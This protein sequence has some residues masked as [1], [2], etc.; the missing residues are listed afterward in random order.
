MTTRPIPRHHSDSKELSERKSFLR[1]LKYAFPP[2]V[3]ILF[4]N[5]T[6]INQNVPVQVILAFC[7]LCVPW[8]GYLNWQQNRSHRIPIFAIVTAIYILYFA[9]PLFWGSRTIPVYY[10]VELTASED[11]ITA[12][13]ML[14]LVGLLAIW[15]GL[16]IPLQSLK[17]RIIVNPNVP[18]KNGVISWNYVRLVLIVGIAIST[19]EAA[20]YWFG[21]AGRQIMLGLLNTF[22]LVAALLLF[23]RILEGEADKIDT[24]LVFAFLLS[25]GVLNLALGWVGPLVS[26]GIGFG[27]LYVAKKRSFPWLLLLAAIFYVL[28][29]QSSKSGFRTAFWNADEISSPLSRVGFWI[30]NSVQMWTEVSADSTGQLFNENLVGAADRLSLLTQTAYVLEQTPALVPFQNG[31]LYVNILTAPIPRFLW[32]DKPSTSDPNRFYQ[33]A[34]R[35]TPPD[36]LNTVSISIGYLVEG[37]INFGWAGVAGVGFLIGLLLRVL[38]S[39]FLNSESHVFRFISGVM[40]LL[41]IINV[42]AQLGL[43]LPSLLVQSWLLVMFFLPLKLFTQVHE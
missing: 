23:N 29:F 15:A 5:V 4:L 16:R 20:P 42:E 11:Q 34:Y 12:S 2:F 7:M 3:A 26:L 9:L 43:L 38:Q 37:Y 14:V 41:T 24:V 25:K 1:P 28:F 30:E 8:F 18:D 39:H 21:E 32:L 17:T 19:N 10:A 27:L 40:L 22:P 6:S 31:S 36:R 35:L 33:V 13:L